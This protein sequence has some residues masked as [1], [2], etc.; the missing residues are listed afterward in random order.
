M[1]AVINAG[2]MI[3]VGVASTTHTSTA[4]NTIAAVHTVL[5]RAIS[6]TPVPHLVARTARGKWR[7]VW[8]FGKRHTRLL[9]LLRHL[10]GNLVVPR[11]LLHGLTHH[12][13]QIIHAKQRE[14]RH[15]RRHPDSLQG[16]AA[17]RPQRVET[18]R[19]LQ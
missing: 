8:W 3:Y 10:L 5:G 15:R 13:R 7:S 11:P 4:I 1:P 12:A 18:L 6:K 14:R 17:G 2:L 9:E 16:L 19:G